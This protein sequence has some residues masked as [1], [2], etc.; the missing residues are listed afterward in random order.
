MSHSGR[1]RK[2]QAGRCH[3]GLQ[4]QSLLNCPTHSLSLST[5]GPPRNILEFSGLCSPGTSREPPR[6]LSGGVHGVRFADGARRVSRFPVT[7]L[8]GPSV[9]S[10]WPDWDCVTTPLPCGKSPGDGSSSIHPARECGACRSLALA[11]RLGCTTWTSPCPA[12]QGWL[13][14]I[15]LYQGDI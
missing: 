11:G 10:Q 6:D 9:S 7:F 5:T 8:W 14:S 2:L 13:S 15:L 3:A 1:R 4:T 12:L